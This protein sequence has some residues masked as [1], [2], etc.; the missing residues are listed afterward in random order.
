M[1][2]FVITFLAVLATL[3]LD[4]KTTDLQTDWG[5]DHFGVPQCYVIS[6]NGR[7]LETK[8]PVSLGLCDRDAVETEIRIARKKEPS[9]YCVAVRV[10][11]EEV[12]TSM[13]RLPDWF[14]RK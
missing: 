9:S 2:F 14:C 13:N 4:A 10:N 6:V 12:K 8:I 3:S 1:K 5:F 11:G 7:A